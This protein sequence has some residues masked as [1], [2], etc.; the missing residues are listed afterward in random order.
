[1]VLDNNIFIWL[2]ILI[3]G[4]VT[5]FIVRMVLQAASDKK[6]QREA[7]YAVDAAQRQADNL[8]KEAEIQA[9]EF[10][11][12]SRSKFS[13]ETKAEREELQKLEKRLQGRDENLDR[14]FEV[15]SRFWIRR[16]RTSSTGK[17]R[18]RDSKGPF[19]KRKRNFRQPSK[20]S[21]SSSS[22]SLT[23]PRKNSS[24]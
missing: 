1:M 8:L 5:G 21:A 19:P 23:R 3:A 10:L 17:N 12:Q 4:I 22:R 11:F 24:P 18:W 20:N 6:K 2:A 16:N 14:K 9:K 15:S 7:R 13:E